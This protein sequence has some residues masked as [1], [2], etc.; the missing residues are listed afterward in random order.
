MRIEKFL[1]KKIFSKD[2][3]AKKL[4]VFF[5]QLQNKDA[6]EVINKQLIFQNSEALTLGIECEFGLVDSTTYHP[7]HIA[8][9]IIAKADTKMIKNEMCQHMIEISTSV[10]KNIQQAEEEL[11]TLV[12]KIRTLLPEN[13]SL[14]SL[15]NLP[16]LE[17]T[18]L[19]LVDNPRYKELQEKRQI[20]LERFTTLGMH[21][22]LGM[23]NANECIRFQNFFMHFL[24]HLLAISA[25]SPFEAGRYTGLASIRPTITES[26]PIAGIPYQFKNW[27]DY[28]ELCR[29][30]A[31]ANSIGN[32]KDL[33]WDI[34]PCP[35]YGTLEIRICDQPTTVAGVAA[36]GAFVHCLAHWFAE[37]QSWLDE[38]PRPSNWRMRENKW[39]AMRYGLDAQLVINNVGDTKPIKDDLLQW[40]ERLQPFYKSLGYEKYGEMLT[41]II[42][43]GNG[44]SRQKRIWQATQSLETVY[45]YAID[46]LQHGT[47]LWDRVDALEQIRLA[48]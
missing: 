3:L 18:Q 39:R 6:L 9:D 19:K 44:A 20:L 24:P 14:I 40:H 27:E 13:V 5:K 15:G 46:E 7:A 41:A 29:S 42:A 11:K 26:L 10:C 17:T 30:M 37:H 25:N 34:R 36:I 32:I 23:T 38:M 28:K 2:F 12:E 4:P 8:L 21:V 31:R 1:P 35:Q 48:S 33:W 16:L 22:H 45:A 47:P 43:K